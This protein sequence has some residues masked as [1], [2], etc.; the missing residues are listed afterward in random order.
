MFVDMWTICRVVWPLNSIFSIS[1]PATVNDASVIPTILCLVLTS[2]SGLQPSFT[3][4]SWPAVQVW[5]PVSAIASIIHDFADLDSS[6]YC[7]PPSDLCASSKIVTCTTTFGV[8][9]GARGAKAPISACHCRCGC[10]LPDVCCLP[11]FP[12]VIPAVHFRG[13]LENL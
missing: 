8:A 4:M 13:S 7:S 6:A 1:A 3:N 10:V 11:A 2:K 12:D 9:V 5:Q